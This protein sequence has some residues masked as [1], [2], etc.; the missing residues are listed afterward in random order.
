MKNEKMS[1]FLNYNNA[2]IKSA[3]ISSSAQMRAFLKDTMSGGRFPG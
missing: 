2:S 3:Y 1:N